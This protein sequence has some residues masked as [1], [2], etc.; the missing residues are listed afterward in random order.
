MAETIAFLNRLNK[1]TENLW[2]HHLRRAMPQERIAAFADLTP[3][4]RE[5]AQ[6]AIVADPDP[7]DV[8]SLVNL[9]WIHS[10]WAGVEKLAAQLPKDSTPIIRLRDPELSRTMAEAVLAWCLYIQRD[11]PAYK[12]QQNRQIWHQ[13][14]YRPAREWQVG[15]VGLGTLGQAAAEQLKKICFQVSGWSRTLKT[16]DGVRCYEGQEGLRTLLN[17]SDIVVLL[18]PL[19]P[20]TKGLFNQ[21]RFKDFKKGAALINFAR[22]A[23]I[24]TKALLEA[25]ENNTLSHA[26]LDVFIHEPVS[27]SCPYWHHE[28]V[29]LL[30]HISAPTNPE[31]A[32]KIVASHIEH[33]R[34]SGKLPQTIDRERGY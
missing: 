22:G 1:E 8:K 6:I 12:S 16:I 32:A 18:L 21:E 14:P 9:Q 3:D 20:N 31:S 13:R 17:T 7:N 34:K 28:K 33:W 11:M 29:T 10:V 25:L 15:I 2:L 27:Q 19:T 23:I 26:V 24:E 5:N 4:E 30:P